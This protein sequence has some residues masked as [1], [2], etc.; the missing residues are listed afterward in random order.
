MSNC[1]SCNDKTCSAKNKNKEESMQEFLE[2]QELAARMC[3]IKHKILVLSGK[4]GVGKSTVAAN[5]AIAL[6]KQGAKT[7]LL[8]VDIHGPSVPTIFGLQK[9]AL[10]QG[11]TPNSIMPL[12]ITEN[13]SAMSVGFLLENPD[14]ALIWRGPMKIGVIKQFLKD[15]QWGDLDY[16]IADL[17][18]GTGDEPLSICQM[19]E[20]IDGAVI[21]T[22]PQEMALAD[23]RKSIN[24]C[25]KLN[26]PII[27][28]LEN[29]SFFECPDCGKKSEIFNN[30]G[31]EN[32][33]K[34]MNVPFLG[35]IPITMDISYNAENSAFLSEKSKASKYF[36]EFICKISKFCNS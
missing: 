12:D 23:V 28:V 10:I 36:D 13:L 6:S 31:T 21:V 20:N 25:K 30:S 22:T 29:M 7:G 11:S 34:K 17:P 24:F 27:G 8:D 1:D 19:I 33:C 2:R 4:G 35:K 15:V 5:F 14:D 18:P 26:V 9:S 32:M 3:A 16:L